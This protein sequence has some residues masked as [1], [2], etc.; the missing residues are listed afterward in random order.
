MSCCR[1]G[2][3]DRVPSVL[4]PHACRE[5]NC[6]VR[7]SAGCDRHRRFRPPSTA[8]QPVLTRRWKLREIVTCRRAS[9][10]YEAELDWRSP[11]SAGPHESPALSP[12][13]PRG[14]DG[15]VGKE[16][17]G[18]RAVCPSPEPASG[19]HRRRERGQRE[20]SAQGRG[21]GGGLQL[22]RLPRGRVA[23]RAAVLCV[24][25]MPARGG[26]RASRSG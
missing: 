11:K 6:K 25:K 24:V 19:T 12:C 1:S 2:Q 23:A 10:W 13:A 16:Q 9:D 21:P 17:R 3:Q 5:G 4:V 15:P 26:V 8:A 20:G 22:P 14:W 18:R 7:G